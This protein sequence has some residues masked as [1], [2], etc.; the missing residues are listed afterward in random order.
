MKNFII[1]NLDSLKNRETN[2][3][4][5]RN[6]LRHEIS[7]KLKTRNQSLIHRNDYLNELNEMIKRKTA[8][9]L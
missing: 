8:K 3:M 5:Q 9:T 6:D 4:S 7:E 2:F 1:S